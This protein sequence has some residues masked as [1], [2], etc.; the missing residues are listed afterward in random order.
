MFQHTAA[1]RRL[2]L[3]KSF[4]SVS[5]RFNTQPP[6]GG[7][8]CLF[9]RSSKIIGFQHTAARRRLRF[10]KLDGRTNGFSFNT[11]PPEGGC[12]FADIGEN[13]DTRFQHTAARRRLPKTK[14]KRPVPSS[15]NTQPPEGG[16]VRGGK[17]INVQAFGFN[18]QPPEG[19]CGCYKAM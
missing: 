5:I 12:Q 16:C 17:K 9:Y 18:T 8:D 15:F 14:Y 6:E 1:R 11:Q 4:C 7:C 13:Q 2:P 3:A 19:G 10:G